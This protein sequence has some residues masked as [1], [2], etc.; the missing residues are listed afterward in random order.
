MLPGGRKR[1][2]EAV[3]GA[4]EGCCPARFSGACRQLNPHVFS[5][6]SF[7]STIDHHAERA[8][9]VLVELPH[10]CC[11]SRRDRA[12]LKWVLARAPSRCQSWRQ[13][14]G[15]SSFRRFSLTYSSTAALLWFLQLGVMFAMSSMLQDTNKAAFRNHGVCWG[16]GVGRV[17]TSFELKQVRW[18]TY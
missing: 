1:G 11:I 7:C 16:G 13:P 14:D 5:S 8:T 9:A 17:L 10:R 4:P 6:P 3:G 2:L 15:M 12:H 18:L